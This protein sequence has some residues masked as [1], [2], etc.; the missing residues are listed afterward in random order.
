MRKR[1]Q[2]LF[3]IYPIDSSTLI[4]AFN[5]HSKFQMNERTNPNDISTRREKKRSGSQLLRNIAVK[6][7]DK[8]IKFIITSP[9]MSPK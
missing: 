1:V 9:T 6:A 7:N 8:T 3:D 2:K 4:E 5:A